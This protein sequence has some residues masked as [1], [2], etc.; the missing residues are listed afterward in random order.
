[1]AGVIFPTI[2]T[3][4]I[5]FKM[6][7]EAPS[8]FWMKKEIRGK[9]MVMMNSDRT[10]TGIRDIYS[11]LAI[12]VTRV[13]GLQGPTMPRQGNTG[14]NWEGLPGWIS[15]RDLQRHRIHQFFATDLDF[16]ISNSSYLIGD[17]ILK[18]IREYIENRK[19]EGKGEC[20]E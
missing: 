11:L 5:T 20:T 16:M 6:N 15:S 9:P 17:G 14:L 2:R 12:Q 3:L 10:C 4:R 19:N 7:W 1:M 13:T 18:S 8:A